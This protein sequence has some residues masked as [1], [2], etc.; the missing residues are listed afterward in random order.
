MI[1]LTPQLLDLYIATLTRGVVDTV[2]DP[3]Q[4]HQQ[5]EVQHSASNLLVEEINAQKYRLF[6]EFLELMLKLL[7]SKHNEIRKGTVFCFVLF[8]S[9]ATLR[10]IAELFDVAANKIPLTAAPDA[11]SVLH[12]TMLCLKDWA[13]DP[14]E[15][16][17]TVP[18]KTLLLPLSRHGKCHTR[19]VGKFPSI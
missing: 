13:V 3:I 7:Q 9:V 11:N 1:S 16:L 10:P 8:Y 17:G 15:D 14:T 12:T 2:P 4:S 6:Q 19:C 5:H 18:K